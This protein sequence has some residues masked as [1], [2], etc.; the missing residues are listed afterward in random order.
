MRL[1]LKM[2]PVFIIFILIFSSVIST[3][4]IVKASNNPSVDFLVKPEST[5]LTLN[6][7]SVAHGGLNINVTPK[8]V[9]SQ[10]N[11]EPV[12]VVFVHDTSGSMKDYF[13]KVKKSVS[14]KSA[15][16][17]AV[18]YFNKNKKTGDNFYLVPF[19]SNVRT[20]GSVK[21]V[22]GLPNIEKVA[23]YLD[24]DEYNIDGTNYTQTLEHAKN[25]LKNSSNKNKYIIFLTDGEPTVLNYGGYEYVLYTNGQAK[26]RGDTSSKNYKKTQELINRIA[27][28]TSDGLAQSNIL[29]YS[30]AFAPQGQ[31]DFQLL[32]KMSSKTGGNAVLATPENLGSIFQSISKKIDS[33]T[34][35]G[36]V[37]VDLSS[38][39]GN[40]VADPSATVTVDSKNIAHI[41]F[42]FNYA[43]GTQPD[44]SSMNITLP[45]IFKKA[46]TYTFNNI[47]LQY[48]G[49]SN[50]KVHSS[51]T[52]KVNK[53]PNSVP[54]AVFQ[55]KPSADEFIKPPNSNA[56]G[57]IDITITP[58]GMA[59]RDERA[60]I[61]LVFV[62][63]TSGSMN[64]RFD[65]STKEKTAKNALM[66][67]VE[68][69]ESNKK[70]HDDF[71]F[72]PFDG[73]V[74]D[75]V[76][77]SDF[78]CLGKKGTVGI[79]SG[80]A[81]IR[82]VAQ[83]LDYYYA[84]LGD[85]NYTRALREAQKKFN[86]AKNSNKYIIFLTDGEPK[87]SKQEALDISTELGKQGIT[88]Y[89][90]GFGPD[91]DIDFNLLESMS[92]NTGG[93][94]V[95]SNTGDLTKIF[96]DISKK[97]NTSAISGNVKI[98]LGKFKGD[99]IVDPAYTIK[100]DS[101]GVVQIPF[102]ITFPV[103]ERPDPSLIQHSLPLQF[104]K[105]G[106]YEFTDNVTMTFSDIKGNPQPEIKHPA[107]KVE[108]KNESAP[109]FLNDVQ[110]KGNQYYSADNLV[111]LGEIDTERNEFTVEYK[112][113]P[114]TVFTEITKGTISKLKISQPLFNG[115]SLASNNPISLLKDGKDV[116]NGATVKLLG[117]MV[118]IDLGNNSINYNSGKFDM[119]DYT[120][121]LK[122]KADWALPYTMMPQ[123]Q[124]HFY[125]SRFEQQSQTLNISEQRIS[126]NVHLEGTD[127]LYTGDSLGTITKVSKSDGQIL[128]DIQLS[129]EN[130]ILEKPIKAMKLIYNGTAIEI[131]YFDN[132]KAILFLKTDYTLKNLSL[133]QDLQAGA[134]T[135]GRVGFKIT[136]LVQG[137]NV[138]YE[139]QIKTEK[140]ESNWSAFDPTALIELPSDLE[141][142]IEIRVRTKGGFS[143]NSTP[144][145]KSLII[146][147][148][149]IS[150][151]P[152][153]IELNVG[154]S[155][156]IE[157]KIVPEDNTM[158]DFEVAITDS[159]I[160]NY[161]NG[162]VKGIKDGETTLVVTTVDVAGNFI[163]AEVEIKV[164]PILISSITVTPN[165]VII[166]KFLDFSNFIVDIQPTNA[167]NKELE[168]KSLN[169]SIASIIEAGKVFGNMT[170]TA[171]IE[172]QAK[173]GSGTSTI[174]EV[175]VGSKLTGI[176]VDEILIIEKGTIGENVEKYF[177]YSPSDVTNIKGE[178]QYKSKNESIL[179]VEANGEII[180]KRIGETGIEIS[181]RDEDNNTFKAELK[182]EVVEPGEI[183]NGTAGDKY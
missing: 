103:G 180:P 168:W 32:Q 61:D 75:K 98:D 90:I 161:E 171:K 101:N 176:N 163:K 38:F 41:P 20:S 147:K 174:I 109:F 165:P 8:G 92:K 17:S 42:K 113:M 10:N 47:K 43:I 166:G 88:M 3:P 84:S 110:I 29:I 183:G 114:E 53:D 11:R 26:F 80:L 82:N 156:E 9:I 12:D 116:P 24:K 51:I 13:S 141:G 126:M 144:I 104:K 169:P 157:I 21:V 119:G 56:K 54:G 71:H 135:K 31:V 16:T 123:A 36:E 108:V 130:E 148:E 112:L 138:I 68:Y 1:K 7:D 40:V 153:P 37:T 154:E 107:F 121:Q 57:N 67:A 122:L 115:I 83:Y 99:V 93:Y 164:N 65:G 120:I 33:Y 44:P 15:L 50:P 102:K 86:F 124:L 22:E 66:E 159:T 100:E 89:S 106:I 79:T 77:C 158:R 162:V 167:T 60:A 34:I 4:P 155:K 78:L 105:A 118:E 64:D 73:D 111:K 6:A 145:V 55:V 142:N 59:P 27:L 175:I 146:I 19:N 143:L 81:N 85:T 182:V 177:S 95:R 72:I 28:E 133:S 18:N 2:F 97:V 137:D 46:D 91:K 23:K 125:D 160:A 62:H 35:S 127:T 173:D 152:K 150:V 39:N 30:V 149:S 45:L 128:A 178:P 52:I 132:K 170:G 172:I 151:T 74:K 63:D 139:Y 48:D 14:A 70:S 96:N 94:A 129:K 25:L 87:S 134:T 76:A 181:V 58:K 49:L 140:H 69:F 117:N 179:E 131:T 5:E 136:D